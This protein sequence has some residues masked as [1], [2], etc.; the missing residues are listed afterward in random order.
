MPLPK[1]NEP[2]T[3]SCGAWLGAVLGAMTIGG[4]LYG[5]ALKT[6]SWVDLKDD[7]DAQHDTTDTSHNQSLSVISE[8]LA[9]QDQAN[10]LGCAAGKYKKWY[11]DT[12]GLPWKTLEDNDE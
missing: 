9:R 8:A 5:V 11:C 3:M 10:K 7:K 2:V 1:P 12:Q 4:T 6:W